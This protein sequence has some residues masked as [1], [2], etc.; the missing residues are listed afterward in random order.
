MSRILLLLGHQENRRLL[1]QW[2]AIYHEVLFPE[3]D[4][5]G[6]SVDV[7]SLVSDQKIVSVDD[8]A[9][10]LEQP[11]DLCILDSVTLRSF[12]EAL[13]VKKESI[14]P[15]F[16]PFLLVTSRKNINLTTEHLWQNVD[17]LIVTPIQKEELLARVEI[18]LRSRQ[19]SLQLQAAKDRLEQLYDL[20]S[21]FISMVAHEFRNPMNVISLAIETLFHYGDNWNEQKK[22]TFL[23][24]IKNSTKKMDNLLED[25]LLIGRKEQGRIKFVPV[26]VNIEKF[27]TELVAEIQMGME[28][29]T[30]IVLILEGI[31][32]DIHVDAKLLRYILTDLLINAIKYSPKD[33]NVYFKVIYQPE[34]IVFEIK[35]DGIGILPEDQEKLFD[36]FYRGQNVEKITG[37]GLG[38]AI[39]K[40]FVDLHEGTITVDS[41]VGVGSTFT[42]KLPLLNKVAATLKAAT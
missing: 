41:E 17:E 2:L 12:K 40:Q 4:I 3:F 33:L 31:V 20:K 34:N 6:Q 1:S 18:L 26:N 5:L 15:V 28:Q 19:L 14:E 30:H 24:K 16:L 25:V 11:F 9:G 22:T 21:R 8:G 29:K 27:C 10:V 42:V 13:R 37:T 39:V 7:D 35:D 32:R 23:N 36:V 38:L